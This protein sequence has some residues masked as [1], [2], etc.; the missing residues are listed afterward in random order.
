[1]SLGPIMMDLEGLESTAAERDMLTHPLVG[2]VI[3]FARNFESPEQVE[4]LTATLH[5]LREPRL[6]IAVDQEGGRVQRFKEG[7]TPLPP[8]GHFGKI[9]R[10]S[11]LQGRQ[12]AQWGGWLMA[13]ELRAVG[14]DFSFAPVLDLDRGL[15]SVIGDR[16]FGSQP[17]VVAELAGEWIR[18]VHDAG[19]A[20]VGKHFPGHG[21]VT[22]D[23]HLALPVDER[24]L[25]ILR[26]EDLAPFERAMAQGLEAIM[27]AHVIYPHIDRQL[28]G[29]SRYW[30]QTVLRKQM[31]FQ[32]VIFSDD[33][34]MAAAT[35]QGGWVERAEA[36]LGAGCDMVLVCNNPSGVV[37][38]LD[39]LPLMD[40]PAQRLRLLRM[41]GRKAVNRNHLR[42]NPRWQEAVR[43]LTMMETLETELP[44]SP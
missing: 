44:L 18:G 23:S 36:A 31:G 3:L 5:Q 38:L 40:D 4:R 21:G 14:V 13:I 12:L 20:A 8:A 24:R 15:N 32:G 27:P 41:H 10:E 35:V 43:R 33:L 2:G 37:A 28:A 9:H 7:F 39:H 25:E 16:A 29:F 26:L 6:L 19:M 22:A 30:L 17:E 34:G 42:I 1:M 11:P